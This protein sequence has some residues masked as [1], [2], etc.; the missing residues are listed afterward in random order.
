MVGALI[1]LGIEGEDG[2]E[3]GPP[4]TPTP[5]DEVVDVF[6]DDGEWDVLQDIPNDTAAALVLIE[7]TGET[8]RDAVITRARLPA[9]ARLDHPLDLVEIGLVT[10]C[11]K[12]IAFAIETG[13]ALADP[14]PNRR[15]AVF[16]SRRVARRPDAGAAEEHVARRRVSH[17]GAARA[18]AGGSCSQP[19]AAAE[20]NGS[21]AASRGA[22]RR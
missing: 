4:P 21:R 13:A 6:S 17:A 15:T 19:H 22:A 10:A 20:T 18:R 11:E 12:P 1:G 9:S 16:A 2:I 14:H 7:H 8:L 3:P 5:R